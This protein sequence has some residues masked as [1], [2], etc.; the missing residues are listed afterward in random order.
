MKPLP[1]NRHLIDGRICDNDGNKLHLYAS[2]NGSLSAVWRDA[3]SN[4]AGSVTFEDAEL[5]LAQA[6]HLRHWRIVMNGPYPIAIAPIYRVDKDLLLT[7]EANDSGEVHRH[8]LLVRQLPDDAGRNQFVIAEHT[9]PHMVGIQI[10]RE[11]YEHFLRNEALY[12]PLFEVNDSVTEL[13]TGASLL[14][15]GRNRQGYEL[16][17]GASVRT[18]GYAEFFE[19][20]SVPAVEER[21]AQVR[22]HIAGQR[23]Q[24]AVLQARMAQS[25]PAPETA[26]AP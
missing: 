7:L 2:G 16:T 12:P 1:S 15:H 22:A 25:S 21:L 10:H 17:D 20:Y 3:N 26:P 18:V 5:A 23:E 19:Q 13:A 11:M 4:A 24:V 8:P 14:M 6:P 9:S